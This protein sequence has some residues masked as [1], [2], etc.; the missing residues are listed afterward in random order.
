MPS[1]LIPTCVPCGSASQMGRF[2]G[3]LSVRTISSEAAPRNRVTAIPVTI[4][5]ASPALA[6]HPADAA[7]Q[8]NIPVA[9]YH[10]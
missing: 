1:T 6:V 8:P 10:E 3:G 7:Q 4:A 5:H 2:S 9:L